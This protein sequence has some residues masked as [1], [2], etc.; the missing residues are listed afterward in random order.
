MIKHIFSDMDHTLLNE[1]GQLTPATIETIK[2]LTI[3]FTCVS[4][5]AP[6]EMLNAIEQLKLTGPQ[7]AFNGGLIFENVSGQIE[8]L[9]RQ[10]IS[11]SDV[12]KIIATV[13]SQFPDTSLSWYSQDGWFTY[14]IDA[15]IKY[16]YSLTGF[17]PQVVDTPAHQQAVFKIMIIEARPAIKSRIRQAVKNLGLNNIVAKSTGAAYYEVTARAATKDKGVH[18]I[19]EREGLLKNET[20]AFGDGENDLPLL[21]AVGTS[22]A[23]GN[24]L[25]AVKKIATR[26]TGSNE[27]DGVAIEL[28][29]LIADGYHL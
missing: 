24:A 27:A 2:D 12:S 20:M 23:M 13:H 4:A 18:F 26:V 22:V 15:G 8:Y 21:E 16:E 19:Q 28:E 6:H 7:I 10:P 25:P 5:R 9:Y 1:A 11:N 3:P 17:P 29:K 14:K